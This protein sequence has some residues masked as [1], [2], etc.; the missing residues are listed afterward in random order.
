MSNVQLRKWFK[1]VFRSCIRSKDTV[2]DL[3]LG[4]KE[5]ERDTVI[6]SL[7]RGTEVN[8]VTIRYEVSQRSLQRQR[9]QD[10]E[11]EILLKN[12]QSLCLHS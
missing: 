8:V 12:K 2:K 4:L 9:Y 7:S 6:T 11:V 5:K 3:V 10:T 1:R